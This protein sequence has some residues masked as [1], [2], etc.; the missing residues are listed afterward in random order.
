[1]LKESLKKSV[2]KHSNKLNEQRTIF[3]NSGMRIFSKADENS[4]ST[5]FFCKQS[6]NRTDLGVNRL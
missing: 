2:R 6:A 4:H 5:Q 1:M 3:F